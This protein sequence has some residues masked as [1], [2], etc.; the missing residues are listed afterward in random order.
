MDI[1]VFHLL[2]QLGVVALLS[3][4]VAVVPAIMAIGYALHRVDSIERAVRN[5]PRKI[6]DR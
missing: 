2:H 4:L 3:L 6:I 5:S 1:S